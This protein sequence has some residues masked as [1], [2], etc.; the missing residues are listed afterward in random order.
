MAQLEI[1]GLG[2]N[3]CRDEKRTERLQRPVAASSVVRSNLCRDE[4][5]TESITFETTPEVARLV[6]TYAAMKSGLKVTS[7]A[8]MTFAAICSNLCRDEKR[9]ESP[10]AH[11]CRVLPSVATYAA[12]KSGLKGLIIRLLLS[13]F[14]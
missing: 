2:S 7:E 6:A 9:T 1:G 12:M 5:R 11:P 13:D 8:L 14:W 10:V 3:L 4:K